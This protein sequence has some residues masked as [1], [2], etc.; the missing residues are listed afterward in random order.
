V[1]RQ[2]PITSTSFTYTHAQRP[3][4]SGFVQVRLWEVANRVDP[5]VREKKSTLLGNYVEPSPTGKKPA[6]ATNL[7]SLAVNLVNFRFPI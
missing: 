5:K 2:Y 4:Q 6:R 7:Q 1:T 3:P